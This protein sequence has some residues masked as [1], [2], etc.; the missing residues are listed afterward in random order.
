MEG[1]QKREKKDQCAEKGTNPVFW[2]E[3]FNRFAS[4][5]GH[6]VNNPDY[7]AG[8]GGGK[9]LKKRRKELSVEKETR[10]GHSSQKRCQKDSFSQEKDKDPGLGRVLSFVKAYRN[11]LTR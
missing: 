6:G 11:K 7:Q 4:K 3:E 8:K 2:N 10:K 1:K 5:S 9:G